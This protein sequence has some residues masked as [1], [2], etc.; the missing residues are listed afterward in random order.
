MN[1][2]DSY[3]SKLQKIVS[4]LLSHVYFCVIYTHVQQHDIY[5]STSIDTDFDPVANAQLSIKV[6]HW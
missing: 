4:A 2:A 3:D 5:L 6:F 1:D